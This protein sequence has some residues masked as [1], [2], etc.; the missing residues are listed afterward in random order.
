MKEMTS[1]W[2]WTCIVYI[3]LRR[4][5]CSL[6]I[7]WWNIFHDLTIHKFYHSKSEN[8]HGFYFNLVTN[9]NGIGFWHSLKLMQNESC[10]THCF[11]SFFLNFFHFL[12]PTI[13]SGSVF[14]NFTEFLSDNVTGI[15]AIFLIQNTSSF[16]MNY[17]LFRS[18]RFFFI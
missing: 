18:S 16:I 6:R 12:F 7:T 8:P 15:K 11:F 10:K 14:H 13:S 5:F 9:M 3:I 1:L 4:R 2:L 17:F